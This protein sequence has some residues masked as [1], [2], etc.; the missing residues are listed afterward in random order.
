M[1]ETNTHYNC[2]IST[3]QKKSTSPIPH[4]FKKKTNSF[5]SKRNNSKF[6]KQFEFYHPYVQGY[7]NSHI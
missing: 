6:I 7:N 1:G 5:H 3:I 2:S 4:T